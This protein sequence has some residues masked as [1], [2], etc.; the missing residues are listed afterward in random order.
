M[1][2]GIIQHT[3]KIISVLKRSGGIR[4]TVAKPKKETDWK[5]GES[6]SINGICL[7]L[8]KE[9]SRSLTFFAS[10]ET[11][12][13]TNIKNMKA[14]LI[15]NM[16]RALQQEDRIGGHIVQGHI[17]GTGRII[18]T[19]RKGESYQFEIALSSELMA[20][21]VE[22][23]SIAVDGISLTVSSVKAKS[24]AV[25]IIPLSLRNT[26]IA[27]SWKINALVNVEVDMMNR[28]IHRSVEYYLSQKRR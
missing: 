16:E 4:L 15:V 11:I 22:K 12:K 28:Q 17:D 6:I 24:F 5:K 21:V 9:D 2:T 8:E 19:A 14:G 3:T 26:N 1:F 20:C 13:K 18:H 10:P 7:S 23:G 27:S 25:D